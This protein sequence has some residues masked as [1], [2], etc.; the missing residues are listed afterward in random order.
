MRSI[1]FLHRS[2]TGAHGSGRQAS[3]PSCLHATRSYFWT[4]S[5]FTA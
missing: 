1:T 5:S 2:A 3:K 4:T